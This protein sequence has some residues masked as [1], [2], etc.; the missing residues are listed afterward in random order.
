MTALMTVAETE[1]AEE[2]KS[3]S[4]VA[5]P[6]SS[7]RPSLELRSFSLKHFQS[8][9]SEFGDMT[10]PVRRRCTGPQLLQLTAER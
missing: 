1:E 4:A 8:T 3:D 6:V 10:D 5:A 9:R 2:A 7:T